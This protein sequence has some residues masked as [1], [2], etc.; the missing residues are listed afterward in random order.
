MNSN[1]TFVS[2]G[3][4][5]R[6]AFTLV[7]LLTV[8]AII[9]L[10][11]GLLLPALSRARNAGRMA[12]SLSNLRQLLI[13]KSQ[14]GY[15]HDDKIPMKM[16]YTNGNVDGWDSWA[17]GGKNN[18]T[19]WGKI[20]DE[21]AYAR[22]LNPYIYPEL[23]I[24]PPPD[25]KEYPYNEGIPSDDQRL[26]LE[27]PAF[28]SPG[29]KIS[30][31]FGFPYPKP[32]YTISSYDDVGTSYHCNMRWWDEIKGNYTF[33]G[34][35]E[36]GMR[37]IKLAADF[38]TTKFVWIHDQTADITANDPHNPPRDWMGEF[39]DLD[40]SCMAFLDGHADYILMIPGEPAGPSYSFFFDPKFGK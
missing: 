31:Q 22:P 40:K 6:T 7:E 21:P 11:I 37:R 30:Y 16:C 5:R 26:A 9:A 24:E 23:D 25:F 35:F 12:V 17:Y 39:G 3:A 27:M 14:Y 36:E 1:A 8:I 38:D 19:R 18:N 29:D 15:D 2:G 13:G 33:E 4:A 20:F 10:L 28:R 34:R 32:D